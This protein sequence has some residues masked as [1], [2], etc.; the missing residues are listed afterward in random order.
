M[1]IELGAKSLISVVFSLHVIFG[2]ALWQ[3]HQVTSVGPIQRVEGKVDRLYLKI[4]DMDSSLMVYQS[5]LEGYEEAI[6]ELKHKV[7]IISD[8]IIKRDKRI[9]RLYYLHDKRLGG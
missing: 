3:M 4:S 6:D 2:G 1:K 8:E 7:F 5:T 9:D